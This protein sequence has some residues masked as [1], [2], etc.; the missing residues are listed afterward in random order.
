MDVNP[1]RR[2]DWGRRVEVFWE[3]DG[4]F[5]RGTVTGYSTSSSKHLILY[6]DG[7]LERVNLNQV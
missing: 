2:R 6:D 3:G 1:E 7:D 5:Y 4:V